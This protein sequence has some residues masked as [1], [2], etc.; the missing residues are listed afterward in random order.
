LQKIFPGHQ[1]GYSDHSIGVVMP[2]VAV[3]MGAAIIEKHITLN[4]NMKGTD[5]ACALE[6]D[7]LWRVVRDIRNTEKS[8][9]EENKEICQ[10]VRPVREKLA[11][12]LALQ[13]PLRKGETITE[14]HFCMR[15]P[16]TGL[17]WEQRKLIMGKKAKTDLPA[18]S[19]ILREEFE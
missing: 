9:G 10:D 8:L 14:E 4:R 2:A 17:S 7:G 3:S 11:R 18:N 15:S 6:P 19:L 5:H 13:A 12:S 1:I 16:G